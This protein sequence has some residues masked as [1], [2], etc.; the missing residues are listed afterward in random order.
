MTNIIEDQRESLINFKPDIQFE[1]VSIALKLRESAYDKVEKL[2][3]TSCNMMPD[4]LRFDDDRAL[5]FEDILD[6]EKHWLC[7]NCSKRLLTTEIYCESCQLFRPLEMYKN[8]LYN[9]MKA[10][11]EEVE[12]IN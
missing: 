4:N 8:I 12:A 3:E 7:I 2:L 10:T 9:P 1:N 6:K 11:D 5:R